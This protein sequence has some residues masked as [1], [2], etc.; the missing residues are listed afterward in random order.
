M[1]T[2][3]RQPAD[4]P[5]AAFAVREHLVRPAGP[6]VGDLLGTADTI[7][8]AR[9]LVPESAGANLGRSPGDDPVIVETWM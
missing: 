2:I 1:Y 4:L 5:G 9:D 7:E 6:V 8:A 3:T